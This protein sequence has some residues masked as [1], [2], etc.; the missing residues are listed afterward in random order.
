MV[1]LRNLDCAGGTGPVVDAWKAV[2]P[3][4]GAVVVGCELE[5]VVVVPKAANG[6]APGAAEVE[7]G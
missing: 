1:L 6:V 7:A 3:A 5:V 2:E 4:T